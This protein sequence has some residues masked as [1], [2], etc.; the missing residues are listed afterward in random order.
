M[1]GELEAMMLIVD[2]VALK[3]IMFSSR[4]C[5]CHV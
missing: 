2:E 4:W 3:T 1:N 5:M